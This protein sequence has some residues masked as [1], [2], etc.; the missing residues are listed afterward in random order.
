MPDL[1]TDA[2]IA[3]S[4]LPAPLMRNALGASVNNALPLSPSQFCAQLINDKWGRDIDPQTAILVTLDYRYTGRPA[5]SEVLA[6]K[7]VT[8]RTLTQALLSNYQAVGDGSFGE[9][10]FGLYTPPDVGPFVRIVEKT[11]E[12]TN[13]LGFI[14]QTYEGIY[15]HTVPQIY[16][17]HTQINLKPADFKA[18]VWQL[19][20]KDLYRAYLDRTWAADD[21][22]VASA[23]YPL[24]TSVKAAFVWAAWLEHQEHR[25]TAHGLALALHAAGLPPDQL[26][27][28]L[29][30]EQL[31]AATVLPASVLASRLKLYRYTATDI[32]SYQDRSS[33]RILLYIPGN[34]SP[35]HE[36][37]DNPQLLEWIVVQGKSADTRQALASHFAPDDRNDGTFHAG[38]LTALEGMAIYPRRHALTKSAGFFNND[39]YWEPA[40][41]VGFTPASSG[42]DPFAQCVLVMKREAFALVDSVFDD[43]QV[44]RDNLSAVVESAVQWINTFGPL[45]LFVPGGE[46]LLALAGI[47]D[48]GYGLDQV[49]KGETRQGATRMIFGLLNALPLVG[50]GRAL[51]ADEATLL[52]RAQRPSRTS[53]V[54]PVADIEV[55]LHPPPLQPVATRAELIRRIGEPV[56]SLSDE[57]LAQI[58]HVTDI[59]NDML[60]L[61]SSGRPMTPML[62]D[63]ISRFRIDQDMTQFIDGMRNST[64]ALQDSLDPPLQLQLLVQSPGWPSAT[65][66]RL[67]DTPGGVSRQAFGSADAAQVI[68]V[69]LSEP[70]WLEALLCRL[71]KSTAETLLGEPLTHDLM[72]ATA[73]LRVR[74]ASQAEA[75]RTLLLNNRYLALQSSSNEW[76]RLFQHEYPGLP[77]SAV[78]QMLDR[79]GV[80]IQVPADPVDVMRVFQRLADKARQ[81]QQHVRLNRAY[82]GLYLPAMAGPESDTLALHSLKNLPGWP[83]GLRFEVLDAVSQGR[84]LDHCGPLGSVD[85]RPLIKVANQYQ[86]QGA[87]VDG[88]DFIAAVLD[89][90][91]AQERLALRLPAMNQARALRGLLADNALTRSQLM[92][93][94]HR[95]DCGLPF[96]AQGLRGGGFPDTPQADAM[97]HEMMRLQ[98][99]DIYPDSSSVQADELLQRAGVGAQAHI[100]ELRRQCLQLSADL[101]D[102]IDRVTDDIHDMHVDFLVAGD[103]AA[104]GLG[105]EQIHGHNLQLLQQAVDHERQTRIELSEELF[106]IWSQRNRPDNRVYSNGDFIGF[107]LNMDAESY[108]RL[109]TLSVRLSEVVELSLRA[110][111]VTEQES[112]DV[113]LE[114]FPNLRTL[115]MEDVDLTQTNIDGVLE[116]CLPPAIPQMTQ[117]TSLNL[118]STQLQFK[119]ETASQLRELVRLEDLDLSN[120]PLVVSPVVLGMNA[121]R[122]LNLRNTRITTCPIGIMDPPYLTALDLRDNQIA[123][124]PPAVISQ[125]IAPGRVQLWGNPLMDEDTLRRL[126]S[127][128]ERTG[129]NLWL[130]TPGADYGTSRAWLH[131]SD[132]AQRAAR[133]S[134]WE[135]VA[136]KRGGIRFLGFMNALSLTADYRVDYLALQARVWRLLSEAQA[137][138]PLWERLSQEVEVGDADIDNPMAILVSLEGRVRLYRDW[139]AM[140][141]PF[142][143][144]PGPVS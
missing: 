105:P 62:S 74:L 81:Y 30:D 53:E 17:P 56:S 129:I 88:E 34:S 47:I 96:E 63:T 127:H 44:N 21:V 102:W 108:H 76:V 131:E 92:L 36:F 112:L 109:P 4:T 3:P 85:R 114:C 64:R 99:K 54:T 48:A 41:Y 66:L 123:R 68:Y 46:G 86:R 23:P 118:G 31:R 120:N 40:D 52:N 6:G 117:L 1:P 18:W 14:H 134:I 72:A 110:L 22:L 104:Q 121:L 138:P 87:N 77:K 135:G 116:G 42:T 65:S 89:H 13:R 132:D 69:K 55:I 19:N 24:R 61:M 5:Q 2:P 15:R 122:R 71:E 119:L 39:G 28:T 82:E 37:A 128:R 124:V 58:G 16:G 67:L 143:I 133:Q 7:V 90:L 100:D 98:V 140:G 38:V 43:A 84:I 136:E 137:S 32:W 126:I 107:K 59:D 73:R 60:R 83:K 115:N 79:Y 49:V 11:D 141:Q 130:G 20:V 113:F 10:A 45:A 93:G 12:L 78:E 27:R 26:W 8:S 101:A 80:D 75:Q 91:S 144:G 51:A 25:L 33:S 125:S 57:V 103:D 106:S 97:T 50:G 139:V 70:G 111:N 95:M 35:L 94:L 142:P 29:E 9:T